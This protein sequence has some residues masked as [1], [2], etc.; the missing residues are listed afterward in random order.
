ML[1]P[2]SQLLLDILRYS[3]TSFSMLLLIWKEEEEKVDSAIKAYKRV[4]SLPGCSRHMPSW[5][6]RS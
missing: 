3:R 4:P 6:L 2:A 1:L 5:L